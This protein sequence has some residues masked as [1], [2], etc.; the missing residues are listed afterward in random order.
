MKAKARD[1]IVAVAGAT[2]RQGGAVARALI[3]DGWK[4]R[5]LT[6]RPH[7]A[8]ALALAEL[9]AEAVACELGNPASIS[10]ALQG[11][12]AAATCKALDTAIEYHQV[13]EGELAEDIRPKPDTQRWLE[14][15]GWQVD[16]AGLARYHVPL[17]DVSTWARRHREALLPVGA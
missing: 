2:G 6:R 3:T 4:V 15:V 1:G 11:E 16:P 14:E 17:T 10:V 9:G 13:N 12:L 5:A 7:S 8:A